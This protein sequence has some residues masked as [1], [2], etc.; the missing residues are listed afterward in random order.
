M[1]VLVD[2]NVYLNL[3]LKREGCE[4]TKSFFNW[5][6]KNKIQTYVTSLSMRDIQYVS[7]K[8]YHDEKMARHILYNVYNS[9]TKV[10]GV[11]A[12]SAIQAIFENGDYEDRLQLNT[13]YENMLDAIATNNIDDFKDST[14]PI[15]LPEDLA[16]VKL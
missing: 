15:F 3:F 1:K 6:I 13:A 2:T 11:S 7:H 16:K 4:A 8:Y 5:C 9:V 10:L 12:D 14:I